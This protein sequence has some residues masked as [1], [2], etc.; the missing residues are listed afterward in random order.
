MGQIDIESVLA[1]DRRRPAAGS[2]PLAVLKE[3][4]AAETCGTSY[5]TASCSEPAEGRA[6]VV[7]DAACYHPPVH[8]LDSPPDFDAGRAEETDR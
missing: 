7:V 2:R 4:A 3:V 6:A 5:R 8:S 1:V